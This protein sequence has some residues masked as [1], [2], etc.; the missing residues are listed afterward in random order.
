MATWAEFGPAVR[1]LLNEIPEDLDTQARFVSGYVV[2][3]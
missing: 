2:G 1:E 3:G